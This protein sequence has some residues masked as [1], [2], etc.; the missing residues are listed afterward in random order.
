ML[1]FSIAQLYDLHVLEL[2]AIDGEA[3]E[4]A[5]LVKAIV[6]RRTRVYMKHVQCLVELHL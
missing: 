6:A 5:H 3:D 4:G 2:R 1:A